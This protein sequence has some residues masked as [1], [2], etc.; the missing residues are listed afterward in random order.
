[1]AEHREPE[2]STAAGNDYAQHEG[3]YDSFLAITKWSI[4]CVVIVLAFLWIFIF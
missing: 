3:M 4:I 2:Y 1:M